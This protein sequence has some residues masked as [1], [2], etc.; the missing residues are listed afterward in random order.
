MHAGHIQAAAFGAAAA[1][2]TA[3]AEKGR[4]EGGVGTCPLGGGRCY[5]LVEGKHAL[6]SEHRGHLHQVLEDLVPV[7]AGLGHESVPI[8]PAATGSPGDLRQLEAGVHREFRREVLH[9]HDLRPR[10]HRRGASHA[11]DPEEVVNLRVRLEERPARGS[12]SQQAPDGPRVNLRAIDLVP[13]DEL[14]RPVP[15]AA[16]LPSGPVALLGVLGG[17]SLEGDV[18]HAGAGEVADLHNTLHVDED[19]VRLQVPVHHSLVVDVGKPCQELAELDLDLDN[20]I[21]RGQ[22]L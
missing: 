19:V 15:E 11:E 22:A 5:Q 9:G 2:T 17:I 16:H 7:G 20:L 3:A 21:W 10:G 6:G 8:G 1:A 14:G 12:L 13:K 18:Q 4:G